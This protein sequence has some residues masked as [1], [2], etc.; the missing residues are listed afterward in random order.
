MQ[1]YDLRDEC[2]NVTTAEVSKVKVP[3]NTS[4]GIV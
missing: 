4:L 2:V 3:P 1:Q